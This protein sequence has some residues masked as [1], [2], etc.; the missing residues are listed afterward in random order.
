MSCR[1]SATTAEAAIAEN[2]DPDLPPRPFWILTIHGC[3]CKSLTSPHYSCK[4]F[5]SA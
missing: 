5:L 4:V 2:D 1:A 3:R